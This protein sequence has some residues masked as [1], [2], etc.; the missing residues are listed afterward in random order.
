MSEVNAR[1]LYWGAPGSGKLT[2]LKMIHGKLR[3]DHRGEIE[4]VPTRIDPR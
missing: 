4:A 1:I 2:N 3:P